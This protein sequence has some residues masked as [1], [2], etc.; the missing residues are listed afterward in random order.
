MGA[1]LTEAIRGPV[2][3]SGPELT[4]DESWTYRLSEIDVSELDA[5]LAVARERS[6][7][8]ERGRRDGFP[9]P[10]LGARLARIGDELE[11]GRGMYLVRGLPTAR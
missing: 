9:L 10:A 3:W 6:P 7:I 8:V 4:A 5:A 11:T 1:I 2:A